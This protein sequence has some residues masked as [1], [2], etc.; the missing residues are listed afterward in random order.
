[1]HH[2]FFYFL[3]EF[4]IFQ[5]SILLSHSIDQQRVSIRQKLCCTTYT[6]KYFYSS[7]IYDVE[8]FK[9]IL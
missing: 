9:I 7:K 1:M 5:L 6:K 4:Y 3:I 2:K 8:L